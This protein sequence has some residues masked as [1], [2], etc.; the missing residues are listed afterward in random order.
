VPPVSWTRKGEA[1]L[2]ER[3]HEAL[4]DAVALGRAPYDGVIVI[5]RHFTSLIDALAMY[6]G[7]P[8]AADPEAPRDVIREVTERVTHARAERLERRPAIA[9][10]RR[11]PAPELVD[12]V[13]DGAEEPAPA[14]PRRYFFPVEPEFFLECAGFVCA[15]CGVPDFHRPADKTA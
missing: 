6:C 12:T 8:V 13:I 10:L 15:S 14:I 5:P 3:T 2:L 7:L 9:D 4:D 1:L 11:G